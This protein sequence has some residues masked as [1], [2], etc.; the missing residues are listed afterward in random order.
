MSISQNL[1][2]E[3]ARKR[4]TRDT[5]LRR[6]FARPEQ[7]ERDDS[8]NVVINPPDEDA[9]ARATREAVEARAAADAVKR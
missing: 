5:K 8:G 7:V 2:D 9:L 6:I 1:R 4:G 3:L